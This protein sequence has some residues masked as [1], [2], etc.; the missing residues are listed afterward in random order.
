MGEERADNAAVFFEY[1]CQQSSSS[2]PVGVVVTVNK[3]L[4]SVADG[5]PES[6]DGEINARKP[7]RVAQIGESSVEIHINV[8]RLDSFCRQVEGDSVG[9]RL[10]SDQLFCNVFF[11]VGR[12]FP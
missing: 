8:F 5:L 2:D 9:K 1:P 4:L 6:F 3:D 12:T 11:T 10:C 7:E